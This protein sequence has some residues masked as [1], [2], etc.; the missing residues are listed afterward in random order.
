MKLSVSL[1]LSAD[2]AAALQA[3]DKFYNMHA[4]RLSSVPAIHALKLR[5]AQSILDDPATVHSTLSDEAA[6]R[7][8]SI[9]DLCKLIVAKDAEVS[10]GVKSFESQRQTMK[11]QIAAATTQQQIIA[12]TKAHP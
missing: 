10:D 4:A 7:G 1:D 8:I 12:I 2:R 6:T 9:I 3:I 11:A 5:W